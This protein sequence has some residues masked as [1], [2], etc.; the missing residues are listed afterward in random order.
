MTT[1]TTNQ[2]Y[3]INLTDQTV[4]VFADRNTIDLATGLP[5]GSALA[6]PDNLAIDHDGNIYIIEDRNGAVDDDI[7]SPRTSITTAI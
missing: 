3:A 6:S 4:G 7:G 5:V 2:V 1:T